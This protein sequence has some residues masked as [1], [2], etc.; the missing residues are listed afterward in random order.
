MSIKSRWDT[1]EFTDYL[2]VDEIEIKNLPAGISVSTMCASCKLNTRLNIPNIEK[3]LQLNPD[4]I[5]TVKNPVVSSVE[6]P[7][8]V[9]DEPAGG[10]S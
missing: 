8:H 3:Y 1:F 6:L 7:C 10:Y 4:D 5:L 9:N 2:N